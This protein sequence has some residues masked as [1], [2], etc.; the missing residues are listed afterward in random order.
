MSAVTVEQRIVKEYHCPVPDILS[1]YASEGLTSKQVAE[2][3]DCG[4]SNVRRIARKYNIRFNQPSPEPTIV[5]SQEF[6][7]RKIN[8][9]N[10]L[11][12]VWH[13]PNISKMEEMEVI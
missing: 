9:I 1:Q 8:P 2:K 11:S 10:F 12:R 6:L 3:L 13:R 7:E 5:Y 4:V